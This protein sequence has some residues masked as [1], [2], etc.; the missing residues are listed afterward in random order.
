MNLDCDR[1]WINGLFSGG[2]SIHQDS[3][4]ILSTPKV[5][6]GALAYYQA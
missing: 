1:V 2:Q 5:S 6:T 3:Q 4:D